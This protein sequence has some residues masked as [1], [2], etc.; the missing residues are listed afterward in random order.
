M[1]LGFWELVGS[2]GVEVGILENN[3]WKK[4]S[5][6]GIEYVVFKLDIGL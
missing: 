5:R 4:E 2:R 6:G 1:G 3:E